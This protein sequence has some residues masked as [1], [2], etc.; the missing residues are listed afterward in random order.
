MGSMRT[1]VPRFNVGEANPRARQADRRPGVSPAD[2]VAQHAPTEGER[3]ASALTDVHPHTGHP[4]AAP[5]AKVRSHFC[6][7]AYKKRLAAQ[8]PGAEPHDNRGSVVPRAS[9]ACWYA[10]DQCATSLRHTA[11]NASRAPRA[12]SPSRPIAGRDRCLGPRKRA[13][14]AFPELWPLLRR[15]RRAPSAK[16]ATIVR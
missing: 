9:I 3:S 14:L 2:R 11:R 6:A 10:L 1:Q 12:V 7:A 15:T 13:S 16:G 8:L 4:D 5:D